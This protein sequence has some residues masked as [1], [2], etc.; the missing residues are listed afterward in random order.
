MNIEEIVRQYGITNYIINDDG[1]TN[2]Y[3]VVCYKPNKAE[4][5]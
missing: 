3:F 4:R 1:S 5:E 2:G